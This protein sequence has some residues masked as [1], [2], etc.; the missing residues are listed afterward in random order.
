MHVFDIKSGIT[1]AKL[2]SPL[3]LQSYANKL[4]Q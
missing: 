1:Y 4:Q 3:K 2:L